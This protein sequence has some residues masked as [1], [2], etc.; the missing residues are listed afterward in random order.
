MLLPGAGQQMLGQTPHLAIGAFGMPA[1]AGRGTD[2]VA[3]CRV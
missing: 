1:L 3:E 2:G